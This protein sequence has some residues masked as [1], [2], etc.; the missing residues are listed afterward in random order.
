[1]SQMLRTN[2][3]MTSGT[4]WHFLNWHNIRLRYVWK[5]WY[6]RVTWFCVN[7]SQSQNMFYKHSNLTNQ[8]VI[9]PIVH[10][11]SF[12]IQL[13]NMI[14]CWARRNCIICIYQTA[15]YGERQWKNDNYC[16]EKLKNKRQK[17]TVNVIQCQ[18]KSNSSVIARP[19]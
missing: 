11:I 4:N 3:E 19:I 17:T 1:M 18:L 10:V 9:L 13:C 12:V 5:F 16:T 14:L 2:K 7:I 15:K 8:Y 6:L